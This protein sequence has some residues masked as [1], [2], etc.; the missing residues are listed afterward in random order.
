MVMLRRLINYRIIVII[1]IIIIRLFLRSADPYESYGT[2]YKIAVA[3]TIILSAV[4]LYGIVGY[5]S[6]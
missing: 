1:I 5:T 2:R 4:N 6:E 3:D